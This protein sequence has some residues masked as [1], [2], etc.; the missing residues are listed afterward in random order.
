MSDLSEAE[1]SSAF[2]IFHQ[3][4]TDVDHMFHWI[5]SCPPKEVAQIRSVLSVGAGT[6]LIDME[7][8]HTLVNVDRYVVI[9]PN[10]AQLEQ[11]KNRSFEFSSICEFHPITFE[12]FSSEM[13]FDLI[14]LS[15]CLYYFD[16][17]QKTLNKVVELLKPTGRAWIFHQTP[18]GINGLQRHF[19]SQKYNY[20]SDDILRDLTSLR[21]DFSLDFLPGE[22]DVRNPPNELIY[23]FLERKCTE[24]EFHRV[25]SYLTRYADGKLPNAVAA[26]RLTPL[27][28]A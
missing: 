19:G 11:F 17:K 13:P 7:V 24:E 15:H 21:A 8:L 5:R 2:G 3:R 23:F 18:N 12:E 27:L 4:T 1:Y 14:L 6:G 26:F 16:D 28:A 10:P 9:E 25:V 20:N 22:I